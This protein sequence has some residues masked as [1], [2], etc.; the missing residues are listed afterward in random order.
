[1]PNQTLPRILNTYDVFSLVNSKTLKSAVKP[2]FK[3][4]SSSVNLNSVQ[5]CTLNPIHVPYLTFVLL[6]LTIEDF[7]SFFQLFLRGR[8]SGL[9]FISP[10]FLCLSDNNRVSPSLSGT[11]S[12]PF[13]L[14]SLPTTGK[15]STNRK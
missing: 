12:I 4:K 2:R 11:H 14:L 6:I 15:D 8:R 3:Q 1:M 9:G 13:Y 10:H 7:S 5:C